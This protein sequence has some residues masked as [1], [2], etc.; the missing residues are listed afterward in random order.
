MTQQRGAGRLQGEADSGRTMVNPPPITQ[1]AMKWSAEADRSHAAVCRRTLP[2][3][4]RSSEPLTRTAEQTFHPSPY[5]Q[6]PCPP[7]PSYPLWLWLFFLRGGISTRCGQ[8][9][10]RPTLHLPSCFSTGSNG[11]NLPY[12]LE[13]E[14][15][16]APKPLKLFAISCQA[17]GCWQQSSKTLSRSPGP[18]CWPPSPTAQEKMWWGTSPT[19]TPVF[20][21]HIA[22]SP[23]PGVNPV[24]KGVFLAHL[25]LFGRD[26]ENIHMTL[27]FPT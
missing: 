25:K 8:W 27:I 18:I 5:K 2:S 17:N 23:P 4:P 19:H 6:P 9:R 11:D 10:Q 15:A 1:R 13:P 12:L 21:L 20:T 7:Q 16:L 3:P 14:A 24:E 26:I 22:H